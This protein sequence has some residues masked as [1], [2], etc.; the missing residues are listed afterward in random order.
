[1]CKLGEKIDMECLM[2]L[3]QF[4]CDK[5]LYQFPIGVRIKFYQKLVKWRNQQELSNLM[6]SE[7]STSNDNQSSSFSA[8]HKVKFLIKKNS[9]RD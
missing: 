2:I 8:G 7:S 4:F 3:D 1:M 5:L 9:A 6:P